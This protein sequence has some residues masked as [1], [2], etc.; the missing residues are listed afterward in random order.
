MARKDR[1]A[2]PAEIQL[3]IESAIQ[4]FAR[5]GLVA[6]SGQRRWLN[7]LVAMKLFGNILLPAQCS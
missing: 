6:D 4:D 5:K 1:P 3:A 2:D 7:G